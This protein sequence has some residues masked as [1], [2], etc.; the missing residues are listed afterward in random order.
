MTQ[1][2]LPTANNEKKIYC[3][4]ANFSKR[5]D[6]LFL[7]LS[8]CFHMQVV[9]KGLI[10]TAQNDLLFS[11]QFC[12]SQDMPKRQVVFEMYRSQVFVIV[13]F[14]VHPMKS[15]SFRTS[16]QLSWATQDLQPILPLVLIVCT[17]IELTVVLGSFSDVVHPHSFFVY[18]CYT[19][20]L[21][22]V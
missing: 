3:V 21:V 19:L 13:L 4:I 14:L 9:Q 11:L 20:L 16:L 12:C 5:L 22:T 7:H 10:S 17:G 8:H 2:R 18:F 15:S 1:G 6:L